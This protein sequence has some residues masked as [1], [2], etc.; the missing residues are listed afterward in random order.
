MHRT[1]P[2][3]FIIAATEVNQAVLDD[4]LDHI[5]AHTWSSD[6]ESSIE[7]IVEVMA[8]SCY[9]SFGP[10]LNPNVTRVRSSNASHLA[11]LLDSGHG[12]TL[13]HAWVSFMLCDVSRTF[14]HELIRHRVG[15][16]ISQESLRYVR[17]EDFGLWIPSCYAKIPKSIELFEAAFA[18]MES[19]YN[20]LIL[21]AAEYETGERSEEAF[22]RLPFE[23]KKEYTS[24]ARRI[25][26]IGL[27]T[28]I[29]WSCNMRTLR[30]VI[31]MRTSPGAEEE[32]RLVFGKVAEMAVLKWPALFGDYEIE[33]YNALPW[34]KT[35]HMKV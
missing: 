9:K 24:A 19:F 20:S 34:Y 1:E 30:H 11:N 31:E 13:E 18:M 27:S 4:Y 17:L 5:G 23:K 25:A 26:P 21:D 6:A 10:G 15:V 35:K 33:M 28:N 7:E 14:T 32:I 29:G 22:T 16:A 12:S 8:R 2:K 3:I